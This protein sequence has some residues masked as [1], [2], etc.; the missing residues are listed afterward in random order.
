MRITSAFAVFI[1]GTIFTLAG[2]FSIELDQPGSELLI[3]LAITAVG[4]GLGALGVVLIKA[5]LRTINE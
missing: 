2:L 5:S 4:V 1:L 3:S